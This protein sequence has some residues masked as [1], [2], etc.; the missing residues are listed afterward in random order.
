MFICE[1]NHKTALI[2]VHQKPAYETIISNTLSDW[3]NKQWTIQFDQ[4]IGSIY[5]V[6][7]G[8]TLIPEV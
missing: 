4:M 5:G 6:G 2:R 8:D 1:A 3:F 7:E